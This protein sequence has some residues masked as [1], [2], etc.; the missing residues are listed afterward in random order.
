MRVIWLFSS[1]AF[2]K[3]KTFY[4][5]FVAKRTIFFSFNSECKL[6]LNA[7]VKYHLFYCCTVVST[8]PMKSNSGK[9]VLG[10]L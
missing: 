9:T 2:N 1:L 10:S 7:Q 3:N 8:E 5:H 4:H 6:A